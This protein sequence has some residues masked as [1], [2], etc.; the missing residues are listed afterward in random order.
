MELQEIEA[1]LYRVAKVKLPS[2]IRVGDPPDPVDVA[3]GNVPEDAYNPLQPK[4]KID[5]LESYLLQTAEARQEATEARLFIQAS[6]KDLRRRW[7]TL[8]GWE[9]HLNGTPLHKATGPQIERARA[10]VDP[11]LADSIES[12]E[13]L[14]KRLDEQIKRLQHDDDVVSRAYTFITGV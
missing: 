12:G 8:E 13:W 1:T 5:L 3:S 9:Q 10:K 11:D 7:R 4:A 6:L 14:D 2:R